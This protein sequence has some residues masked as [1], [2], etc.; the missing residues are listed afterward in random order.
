MK[1]FFPAL[2]FIILKID[3]VR[4]KIKKDST[5]HDLKEQFEERASLLAGGK[6]RALKEY[7]K[8]EGLWD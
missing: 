7:Y 5:I 8:K 1:K 3:G 2:D 6:E 4:L